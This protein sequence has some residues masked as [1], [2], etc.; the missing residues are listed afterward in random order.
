MHACA[1]AAR[2]GERA[3]SSKRPGAATWWRSTSTGPQRERPLRRPSPCPRAKP[4]LE[5]HPDPSGLLCTSL[6][7]HLLQ[8]MPLLG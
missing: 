8:L 5:A 6:R 3:T 7:Q 1:G 2:A 4:L